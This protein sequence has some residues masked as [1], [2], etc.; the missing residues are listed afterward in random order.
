[1]LYSYEILRRPVELGGGWG[2]RLLH[3]GVSVGGQVFP[4][5]QDTVDPRLGA[6]WWHALS[7]EQQSY[8]LKI[9]NSSDPFDAYH[10]FLLARAYAAAE[11]EAHDW[12]E[13]CGA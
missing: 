10:A 5:E 7:E 12:L 9:A 13:S 1:M 6:A 2:L 4:I 11:S 3:N 8:W